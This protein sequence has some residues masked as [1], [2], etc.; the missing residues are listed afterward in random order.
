[1]TLSAAACRARSPALRTTHA[2]RTPGIASADSRAEQVGARPRRARTSRP[3]VDSLA[4]WV[5][6]PRRRARGASGPGRTRTV[7]R[8][9]RD[10]H[11][12]GSGGGASGAGSSGGLKSPSAGSGAQTA[13]SKPATSSGSKGV[14]GARSSGGRR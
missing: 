9:E 5:R 8:A 2:S 7:T 3:L 10:P 1:M 12:S 14:S 13:P 4:E 11:Q 6:A